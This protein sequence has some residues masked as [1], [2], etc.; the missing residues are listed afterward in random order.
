MKFR[1]HRFKSWVG[2]IPWKR[3]W[4]PTPV[5]LSG[6]FYGQRN[7]VGYNTWGHTESEMTERL[8]T[9]NMEWKWRSPGEK[10]AYPLKF[11]E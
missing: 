4:E 2:K 1:R 9:H 10:S 5:F 11:E 3:E 8:S 6:E 7:L